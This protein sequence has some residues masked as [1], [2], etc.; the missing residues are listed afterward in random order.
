LLAVLAL[1]LVPSTALA[2]AATGA[3]SDPEALQAE[4]E[5]DYAAAL[6]NDCATACRALDSMRRATERLCALDP[7]DRCV[8]A[9]RKLDDAT[10]RVRAS[11][12]SCAQPLGGTPADAAQG[13]EGAGATTPASAPPPQ[14][15][16]A[17][18]GAP[19]TENAEEVQSK[20]GGCAACTVGAGADD[21][22][23]AAGAAA[24]LLFAA[25]S[26]RRRRTER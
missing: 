19:A 6:A 10:T 25:C 23:A 16:A 26:R 17:P 21:A 8:V 12:P 2:Q 14:P 7:G 3:T 13:G 22:L 4:I 11:C 24:G 9:R 1:T 5:R 20:R 15:Q 18:A